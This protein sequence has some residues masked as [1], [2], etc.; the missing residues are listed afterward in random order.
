M[1]CDKKHML[2]MNH[3]KKSLGKIN[4]V[5]KADVKNQHQ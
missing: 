3:A 4:D 2:K 5:K 1:S